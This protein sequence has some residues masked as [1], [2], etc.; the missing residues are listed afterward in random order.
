MDQT[1]TYLFWWLK[2][3]LNYSNIKKLI[4]LAGGVGHSFGWDAGLEGVV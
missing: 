1:K 2:K 4:N 3:Y